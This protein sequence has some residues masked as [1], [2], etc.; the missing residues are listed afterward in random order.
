MS[1][2]HQGSRRKHAVS[3]Q[4][5]MALINALIVVAALAAVSLVLLSRTEQARE[6]LGMR[7]DADQAE[8]YLDA[9]ESLV[10][11]LVDASA[12]DEFVHAGQAWASPRAA[13]TIDRGTVGWQLEDLQGRFNINWLSRDDPMGEA[14][15]EAFLHL[16]RDLGVP[17]QLAGR[18][19]DAGDART[20]FRD[21]AFGGS[22]GVS[23][24]PQLPLLL[25][26][27]LLLVAGA[28]EGHLERLLPMLSALPPESALNVNTARPDILLPFLP[29]ANA[30]DLSAFEQ[31]RRERPF[32]DIDAFFEWAEMVLGEDAALALEALSLSTG[33]EWFE[34]RLVARLDTV[35][36][37]RSVVVQRSEETGRSAIT[38]S[39][40]EVD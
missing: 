22:A 33:S 18:L 32:M 3:R 17:A 31:Y 2:A 35:V 37:R 21:G 36:L 8:L 9:A 27:T 11:Q 5:G 12:R 34:A 10:L 15:R 14:A 16:A 30:R 24:P 25:P 4:R 40:P 20:L 1:G 23:R 38:L 26:R 39:L 19:A 6:R 29:G 28:G 7:F 13:E